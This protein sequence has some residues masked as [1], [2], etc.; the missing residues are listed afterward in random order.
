MT[1]SEPD[2]GA[3][4]AHGARHRWANGTTSRLD[5][6]QVGD[7]ALPSGK[8]VA[9]DP[10]RWVHDDAEE[11]EPFTLVARPGEWRIS[12]SVVHWDESPDPRVP[13]PI[14]KPTAVKAELGDVDVDVRSWELALR[15]GQEPPARDAVGLPGFS[16]GAG[17]GCLLDAADLG[18]LRRLWQDDDTQRLDS[19]LDAVGADG[20]EIIMDQDLAGGVLVF[21]CGMGDGVYPTWIGRDSNGDPVSLVIDLE[22][23]AHSTGT[24]E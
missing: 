13:P 3:L 14:R 17:M 9:R 11:K 16:V 15:P 10:A 7:L 23:L 5:V 22:L 18:F 21:D 4:F 1:L 20:A 19:I 6:V 2:V 8:I 24:I 12:I